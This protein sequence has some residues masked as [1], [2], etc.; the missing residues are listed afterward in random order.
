[1]LTCDMVVCHA[2]TG[3]GMLRRVLLH[4]QREADTRGSVR[5]VGCVC[6]EGGGRLC[7]LAGVCVL[8]AAA[9]RLCF[10]VQPARHI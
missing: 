8:L 2:V 10:G 6:S 7:R 5:P 1:V 3:G 9:A 4:W